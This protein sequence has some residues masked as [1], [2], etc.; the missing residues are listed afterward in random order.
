M[1][2]RLWNIYHHYDNDGEY[3][4]AIPVCQH[5]A[6]IAATEEEI[7]EFLK[8]WNRPRIYES[9]YADL[10]FGRVTAEMVVVQTTESIIPYDEKLFL[11]EDDYVI[12]DE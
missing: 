11:H 10:W 8:K 12:E 5:V 1:K 6:T 2:R 9:P 4:D 7:E 3:G